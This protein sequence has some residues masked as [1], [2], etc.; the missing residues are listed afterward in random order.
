MSI[1]KFT[2]KEDQRAAERRVSRSARKARAIR[3]GLTAHALGL[4]RADVKGNSGAETRW[5]REAYDAACASAW[6]ALAV[7]ADSRCS[8]RRP[9]HTAA[10]EAPE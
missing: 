4:D 5:A 3:L 10:K 1:E 8:R 2:E 7:L 6:S 9:R